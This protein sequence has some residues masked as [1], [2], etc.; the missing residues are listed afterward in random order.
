MSTYKTFAVVGGGLIGLPMVA[1]LASRG[2][3][4]I[5]LSRPGSPPKPVPATVKVVHVEYSDTAAVAEILKQYKVEVVIATLNRSVVLL[6]KPLVDA[7]KLAGVKLF[8]PDEFATPTDSEPAGS[9]NPVAGIGDKAEVA[10]YLKSQHIPSARVFTGLFI[11]SIAWL[12]GYSD[13]GKIRIVGK[14]DAPV[15]YTSVADL[16]G[17]TAHILTT[18]P[19]AELENRIFRIQG[20]RAS[21]SALGPIFNTMV[22]HLER[23]PGEAG[24]V[25]T[26]LLT[27]LASG[28]G[29][30]GWDEAKKS[31]KTGPDAAGSANALW[32]GHNWGSI[33]E[34][35]HL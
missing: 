20:D 7:A 31:E 33:R 17:F 4:V 9:H 23:I 32:P 8:V 27:L 5:L 18:L 19:P 15:S 30:S 28:A 1:E 29:S 6:Q 22:E 3:S 11:D 21:L 26:E 12:V 34:V 14:G 2:A 25:K 24:D 13:H 16:T 35:L 10:E